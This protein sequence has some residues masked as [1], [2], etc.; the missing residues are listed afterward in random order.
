MLYKV[1]YLRSINNEILYLMSK[2]F[3]I[4]YDRSIRVLLPLLNHAYVTVVNRAA[5]A[6]LV[7]YRDS[8]EYHR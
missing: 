8:I 7:H 2:D 1:L 6:V 4:R 5:F 3:I